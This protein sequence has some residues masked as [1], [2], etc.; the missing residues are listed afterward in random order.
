MVENPVSK[1]PFNFACPICHTSLA[2]YGVDTLRCPEDSTVFSKENGVWCFLPPERQGYYRQF[3]QEYEFI[4]Q[5][6][7]RASTNP[8]YYRALPFR[9]LTGR[10][11]KDWSVRSRSFETLIQHV[12]EPLEKQH[13]PV[14]KILDLGAGNGWLS[15]QLSKRGHHVAAVD[16]LTNDFDG[17]GTFIHYDASW[18]PVQAEFD[19]LPFSNSQ[20]NLIIF[21]ASFHYSTDYAVTLREALRV[22]TDTG[23]LV[24]LDSPV[25][26]DPGSGQQMVLERETQFKQR[27]GFASNALQS[28]NFLTGQR[29]HQ[30]AVELGLHWRIF[31]PFY[32]VRWS[33]RPLLARLRGHR[34]PAQFAIISGRRNA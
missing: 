6:E 33:V 25:Y 21:N 24:I 8:A 29:L 32:G 2:T 13:S 7:G 14:M 34:E 9:D 1:S 30:L 22:M 4:R 11:Q 10:W 20:V 5:A 15:Y 28:E 26:H 18:T 27:Y 19:H 16:I 17:L 23:M 3:I 12:I 31:T